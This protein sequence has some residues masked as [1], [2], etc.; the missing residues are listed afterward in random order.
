MLTQRFLKLN[1]LGAEWIM[2]VLLALSALGV[3][4]AVDRVLLYWR[5]RE[6]FEPLQRS[7]KELLLRGDLEGALQ[8]TR[9]D[10]F[11]RNVLRAGL[12]AL[13][14]GERRAESVEQEMLA[15]LASERARYDG[16]VAW[17]TT[18]ANIAPLVGLLGTIIGI[19]AAFYGLGQSSAAQATGNPQVMTS[20]AE[21][22]VATAIGILVAVP[23]V[24]TYNLLRAHMATRLRQAEA[25]MRE[26]LAN[27]TR[28]E[29]DAPGE[30]S[31]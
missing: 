25:L 7:L 31:A 14:R 27:V 26:V 18:I 5:T 16:R 10:S 1:L 19:V 12:E 3:A 22:L 20:I 8:L 30:D 11:V 13:R 15:A 28:L 6:G 2:W 21:A 24:V 4:I 23:G 9:R 17:L 29:S